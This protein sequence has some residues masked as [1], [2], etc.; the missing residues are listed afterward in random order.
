LTKK[1][2]GRLSSPVTAS[3]SL[4]REQVTILKP[5]FFSF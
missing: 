4:T 2:K 1:L 3:L 5:F